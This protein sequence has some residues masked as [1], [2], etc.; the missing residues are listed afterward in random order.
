MVVPSEDRMLVIGAGPTGL[1]MARQLKEAEVA[2]DH[3][4]ATDAIGGVWSHGAHR[5]IELVTS[6]KTTQFPEFPMSRRVGA[7][8]TRDGMRA[9][10]RAYAEYFGLSQAIQFCHRVVHIVPEEE[11]RWLVTFES[12]D[13]A[14]Y[15]GVFVCNGHHWDPRWPSYPGEFSGDYI[16][17][18]DFVSPT[19]FAGKR[20]LIIGG[21]NSACDLASTASRVGRSA[22]LSVR[23]G[24]WIM[25]KKIFGIPTVEYI[26]PRLSIPWQ[27][28]V[29]KALLRLRVGDYRKYGLP[30]PDHDLFDHH[31]TISTDV[32]KQLRRGTL[33]ARPDVA[34]F[35][36]PIV[37]FADGT[38]DRF[39]VVVCATGYHVSVP[40]L[41][42]GLFETKG[43]VAQL[44]GG[45]LIPDYKHLYIMATAQVRSG[46]GPVIGPYVKHVRMLMELQEEL[47]HPLS[48]IMRSL[49]EKPPR[50]HLFDAQLAIK[51]MQAARD[52]L[53][54]AARK[55][56]ALMCAEAAALHDSGHL[57]SPTCR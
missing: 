3:V 1:A 11:E 48:T 22:H 44:Y 37:H 5:W 51:K 42:E 33:N 9:Y 55:Q 47:H 45:A 12:G 46:V 35:D 41:A 49:G 17:A 2:Y 10:L 43:P 27:R 15:K 26:S 31:P 39:D 21:G 52:V 19:Q 24:Y 36:G 25:P 23:R 32:L 20:V 57:S 4:E 40:F 34:R 29:L 53:P 54:A 56:D 14:T 8:P 28:R 38:S 30:R 13:R 7:F 18:S 6:R 50:T 16:H